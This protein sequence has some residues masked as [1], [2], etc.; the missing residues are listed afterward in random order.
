MGDTQGPR[1]WTNSNPNTIPWGLGKRKKK[2][3][4]VQNEELL[5]IFKQVQINMLLFEEIKHIPAYAK[6]LKD[7]CT[8]KR[9][10]KTQA[11]RKVVLSE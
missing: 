3:A 2:K 4:V 6:F 9:K 7:V 11:P 10:P 8:P 1:D 5:K